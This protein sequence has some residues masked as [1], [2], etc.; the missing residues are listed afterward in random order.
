M[1]EFERTLGEWM[2][3]FHS[4][5]LFDTDLMLER[6]PDK[7]SVVDA[8]KTAVCQNINLFM[9]LNEEEFA[10]FL[11]DFVQAVWMQLVKVSLR[12]GQV[13]D[14]A[15]MDIVIGGTDPASEG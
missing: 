6:D 14:L 13:R 15:G 8:V 11:S 7:E 9:S 2:G 1:K 3:L 12:P 5:L 4:F 10:S